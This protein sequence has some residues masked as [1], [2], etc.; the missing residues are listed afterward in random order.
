M[1]LFLPAV[2]QRLRLQL[3]RGPDPVAPAGRGA[4]QS[5]DGAPEDERDLPS[6]RR[7]CFRSPAA[8]TNA[9]S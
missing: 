4:D 1:F 7:W 3:P 6:D 2:Y 8:L 5:E 9:E